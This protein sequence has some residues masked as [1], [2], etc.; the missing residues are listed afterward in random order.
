MKK[1]YMML[2]LLLIIS[3][4]LFARKPKEN[5]L[6][7]QIAPKACFTDNLSWNRTY[8]TRSKPGAAFDAAFGYGRTFP[9]ISA[10][11]E[12]STGYSSYRLSVEERTLDMYLDRH[13]LSYQFHYLQ[14]TLKFGFIHQ[15]ASPHLSIAPYVGVRYLFYLPMEDISSEWRTVDISQFETN[16]MTAAR[17]RTSTSGGPIHAF[18]LTGGI[19]FNVPVTKKLTFILAPYADLG[20]GSLRLNKYESEQYYTNNQDWFEENYASNKGDAIGMEIAV[21]YA[22]PSGRH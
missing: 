8:S 1:Q 20:T 18:I 6:I 7:V 16:D 9:A 21:K 17:Y 19:K 4:A 11:L 14:S 13:S 5:W 3:E 15:S 12:L 22:L 10:F 2:V